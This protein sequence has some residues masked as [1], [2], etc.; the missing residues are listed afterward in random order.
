VAGVVHHC[1]KG[2]TG[3]VTSQWK[4][5]TTVSAI[6]KEID[7]EEEQS[8]LWDMISCGIPLNE[9]QIKKLK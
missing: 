9:E 7:C 4:D 8:E 3:G 2:F 5:V 1:E 6:S